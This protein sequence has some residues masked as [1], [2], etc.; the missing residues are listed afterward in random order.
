MRD[1]DVIRGNEKFFAITKKF[2]M[3]CMA[4]QHFYYPEELNF[5]AR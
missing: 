1:W 5:S 2:I 3:R 4:L